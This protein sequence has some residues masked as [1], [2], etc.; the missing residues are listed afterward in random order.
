MKIILLCLF[1]FISW[2]WPQWHFNLDK[3]RQIAKKENRHILL[4]F[5]GSDWCGP[6]INMHQAIFENNVFIA[7]ADSELVLVNADF[8]RMKKNQL[9]SDQQQ[10][11]NRMAD[12][13]DSKGKFPCTVLLDADGK[14]LME[15]D[16][17]PDLMV[18]QFSSQ[19]KSIIEGNR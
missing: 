15:W 12:Q 17:Y 3:S 1:L 19:I 10:I 2:H 8:P 5:S 9:S 7:M 16:G 13:Y 11:N 4:N 6:C 14:L 18:E